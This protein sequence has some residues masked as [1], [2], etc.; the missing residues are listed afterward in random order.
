MSTAIVTG[1]SRGIGAACCRHLAEAGYD[2]A[3]SFAGNVEAASAVVAEVETLGRRAI[4]VRADMATE[5]GVL[6]LFK[7]C[8]DALG[9]PDAV[10]VNA[11]ITGKIGKVAD[12]TAAEIQAVMDLNVV[13]ALLAAREAIRRMSTE[14]GG[15]GG[16]IVILSSAAA[17]IG[18]PNEFVHYAASKGA[19][20][21]M[22]LGLAKE[23]A[24]E[25]IRVNA[26][27]PGLI[28]TDIHASA[29]APD[30]VERLSPMVPMGRSGSADEVARGVSWLLSDGAAYTTGC[31][32]PVSGGR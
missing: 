31:I 28:E 23:V 11:G 18:S 20:S 6:A 8:D 17:W 24:R 10:V 29:G 3:F 9:A 12:M 1:G 26:V 27:A 13:G 14:R 5:D 21:T 15:R 4:S 32:L 7:A 22:T 30:R 16:G 25:G 19:T 2:V